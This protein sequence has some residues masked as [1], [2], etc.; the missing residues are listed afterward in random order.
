MSKRI[1]NTIKS[2]SRTPFDLI[3]G[4]CS[5]FGLLFALYLYFRVFAKLKASEKVLEVPREVLEAVQTLSHLTGLVFLAFILVV[6]FYSKRAKG[7]RDAI[8]NTDRLSN[9]VARRDV[10]IKETSNSMHNILHYYRDVMCL[11]DSIIN[12]YI[13]QD[14]PAETQTRDYTSTVKDKVTKEECQY[15]LNMFDSFLNMVVH[16]VKGVLEV[17]T[18]DSCSVCIK[19]CREIDG[20]KYVKTLYRDSN[21]YRYRKKND[22]H[23][24][25]RQR[26]FEANKDYALNIILAEDNRHTFY[27]EDHLCDKDYY[28][29]Q[30]HRKWSEMY[31]ATVVSRISINYHKSD[32]L[33]RLDNYRTG[34]EKHEILGFLCADNFNGKFEQGKHS[35][36]YVQCRRYL[37]LFTKEIC[38][39]SRYMSKMRSEEP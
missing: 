32:I 3:A 38:I 28:F 14:D 35:G 16:N 30:N 10:Q 9:D 26:K 6:W 2:V 5:I 19:I 24:D 7:E 33:K 4:A 1:G 20:I 27:V 11:F 36:F 17:A 25:G 12:K 22:Y 15:A 8:I 31:Q 23:Q 37:L 29:N 39:I 21:C 34:E 13:Y 18:K